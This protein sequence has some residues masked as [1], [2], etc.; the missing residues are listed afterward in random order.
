MDVCK[1][2]LLG[3]GLFA[4]CSQW[5][6]KEIEKMPARTLAYIGDAVYELGLRMAH[7]RNGIDDAGR[8]HS[9][10]VE[11]VS[12]SAQAKVFEAIFSEL[13]EHEHEL[14]K[15]WRNAKIP[16]RYGS[17]TRAEYARA[18]ALEAWVAYLFLTGQTDRLEQIFE[19]A[20][21]SENESK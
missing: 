14:V 7:V 10:L 20:M 12:S 4:V 18:T 17:G 1:E 16:A 5:N 9:S 13:S 8:L 3:S 19:I 2:N 11:F 6:R 21:R 15:S